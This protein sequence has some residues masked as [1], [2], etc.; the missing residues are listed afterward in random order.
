[1]TTAIK[2]TPGMQA[3]LDLVDRTQGQGV[4]LDGRKVKGHVP[5]DSEV[6]T[7]TAKQVDQRSLF[8]LVR[9]GELTQELDVRL[10]MHKY[11]RPIQP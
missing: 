4:F 1:M 7:V 2:I 6:A 9:A 10:M 3:I 11:R 5:C 8:I